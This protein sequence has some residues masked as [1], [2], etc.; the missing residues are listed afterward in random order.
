M[1]IEYCGFGI[2]VFCSMVKDRDPLSING[3]A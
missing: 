2:F 1:K 3:N